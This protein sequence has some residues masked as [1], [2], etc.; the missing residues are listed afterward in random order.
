MKMKR[1][2]GVLVSL[3][4]AAGQSHAQLAQPTTP[5]LPAPASQPADQLQEVLVTGTLIRGV[6]API[7]SSLLTVDQAE[8]QAS[9]L[10]TTADILR[11][12]PLVSGIGPGEAL[13]N[14]AGGGAPARVVKVGPHEHREAPAARASREGGE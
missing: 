4:L 11:S 8:I 1:P 12:L 13:S 9:G 14:S 7:G 3:C 6:S 5:T 10:Q 2:N